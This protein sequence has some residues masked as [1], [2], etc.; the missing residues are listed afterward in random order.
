[1]NGYLQSLIGAIIRWQFPKKF[2]SFFLRFHK[3]S[4]DCN[5]DASDDVCVLNQYF[6]EYELEIEKLDITSPLCCEIKNGR[7]VDKIELSHSEASGKSFLIKFYLM[8]NCDLSTPNDEGFIEERDNILTS[9]ARVLQSYMSEPN[10]RE[11]RLPRDNGVDV[12]KVL[13]QGM[14]NLSSSSEDDLIMLKETVESNKKHH[15]M[16]FVLRSILSTKD[17]IA[18]F[19][20]MYGAINNYYEKQ[21]DIDNFIRAQL[22]NV[23]IV[24]ESRKVEGEEQSRDVTIYTKI[25][26]KIAHGNDISSFKGIKKD[27][28]DHISELTKLAFLAVDENLKDV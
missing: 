23:K 18:R 15:P 17:Q 20:L 4:S 6:V 7:Y 5:H 12:S 22:P 1:M 21:K 19:V 26:N 13:L 10:C 25:R 28:S 8:T 11:S 27:V 2:F 3:N 14:V 9:I 16:Y 24:K